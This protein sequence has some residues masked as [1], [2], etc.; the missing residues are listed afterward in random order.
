MNQHLD[1]SKQ[2]HELHLEVKAERGS[3]YSSQKPS[4]PLL[5]VALLSGHVH[6]RI[7]EDIQKYWLELLEDDGGHGKVSLQT[8]HFVAK[9]LVQIR[10]V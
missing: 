9:L 10:H 6:G 4:L 8:I 5:F 7:S 3:K 2:P 1:T